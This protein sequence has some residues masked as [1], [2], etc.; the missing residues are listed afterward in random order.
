MGSAARDPLRLCEFEAYESSE[1]CTC[2]SMCVVFVAI[3]LTSLCKYYGMCDGMP[4]HILKYMIDCVMTREDEVLATE[5]V[6][7]QSEVATEIG[8]Q[9]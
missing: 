7:Q 8:V 1:D 3:I 6:L 4:G 5:N 9:T 2:E